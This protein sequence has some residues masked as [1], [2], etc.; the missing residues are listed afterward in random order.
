MEQHLEEA[1]T[2]H[3]EIQTSLERSWPW[4]S[5]GQSFLRL[6]S[7]S[8]GCQWIHPRGQAMAA[9]LCTERLQSHHSPNAQSWPCKHCGC[10]WNQTLQRL[11]VFQ[12]TASSIIPEPR[13][14]THSPFSVP[15]VLAADKAE[16]CANCQGRTVNR[17]SSTVIEKAMNCGFA[18]GAVI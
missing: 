14:E 4:L 13:R 15:F 17:S 6:Q 7:C 9:I 16:H 11:G 1:P 8:R 18:T 2:S 3:T 5:G 10:G 12:E